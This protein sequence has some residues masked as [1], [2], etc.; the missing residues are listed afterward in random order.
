VAPLATPQPVHGT[1]K[2]ANGTPLRGGIIYFSPVEVEVG[3][4]FRYE[5]AALIDAAGNYKLGYNG[6]G[7]GAPTG[8]YKVTIMPRE[9][10]ELP[11]SNSNHIP[12][13]YH[14]KKTTPLLITVNEGD[15][16]CNFDLK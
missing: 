15:N 11:N 14:E 12:L 13:Q 6:D 9:Y 7:S 1:I 2:F 5:A 4:Q 8:E 16:V 10:Q 3:G